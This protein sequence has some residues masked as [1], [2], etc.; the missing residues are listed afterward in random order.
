MRLEE[1]LHMEIY[2]YIGIYIP[3]KYVD[4][5]ELAYV[6]RWAIIMV[7]FFIASPGTSF[8]LSAW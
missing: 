5:G 8:P 1:D 3:G 6:I 4:K 2:S 7:A